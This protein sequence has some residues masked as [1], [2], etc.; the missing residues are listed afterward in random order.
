MSEVLPDVTTLRIVRAIGTTGS[1]R[2]AA[3]AAGLS[4]QAASARVAAT[5]T[6]LGFSLVD[7]TRQG[8]TLTAAGHLVVEW[9]AGFLEQ[10][11]QLTKALR[12]LRT[13]PATHLTVAASQT[14]AESFIPQWM[15]EFRRRT[16]GEQSF[17][18]TSGN[19][20]FV[21][22][23]VR[24]GRA[25]VGLIETPDIPDDLDSALIRH[26]E[27]TV[28]VAPE[29][30]WAKGRPV[31]VGELAVTPL[32]TREAGSGTRRTLELALQVHYPQLVLAEPA[33]VLSTAGAIRA[34]VAS[35]VGPA[36]LSIA[37]VHDDIERGTLVAVR[38]NDLVLSRPLT[39]LW[40]RDAM[41][42]ATTETLF[43]I[44]RE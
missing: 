23:E 3:I 6:L 39:A 31:S 16:G 35:G 37:A 29:H 30:P 1:F 10:A 14:I 34:A 13:G 4:Q 17:R 20:T 41:L 9:S 18:L 8:S 28:V 27:L 25:V 15:G 44:L 26:D 22:D 36:V 24:H 43:T 32:I 33:A 5:E 12:T 42:P 7:R 2:Q 40:A 11:D 19:S 38:I 21:I